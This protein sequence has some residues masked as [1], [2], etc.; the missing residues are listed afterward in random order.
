MMYKEIKAFID[1]INIK[2]SKIN[3]NREEIVF[4]IRQFIKKYIIN[5]NKVLLEIKY[6]KAIISTKKT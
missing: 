1:D 2:S 4:N 5:V 3:Y 6:I